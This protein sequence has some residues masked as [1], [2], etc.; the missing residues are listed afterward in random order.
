[1][2]VMKRASEIRV[3][4]IV[5]GVGFRPFIFRIAR[6]FR[7]HG[8]VWNDTWGVQIHAEGYSGDIERFFEE[9]RSNPPPLAV[10]QDVEIVDGEMRDFEDFAIEKSKV[11]ES[12]STFIPPDTMV[13]EDCLRELGAPDDRRYGYPFITCTNCGPRFSIVEDIPYDRDY[14]TMAT[15]GMCD[16]CRREY[17]DPA[18]RRF[19]TQP[20]ACPVCG[21]RLSLRDHRGTI[22]SEDTDE[23]VRFTVSRLREGSIFA[24]KGVGGY[25]LAADATRDDALHTL[26]ERKRRPFKPFALM[27]GSLGMIESFLEVSEKE[28]ELLLSR[29]RPIVILREKKRCVSALVAPSMEYHGI[30]LP[31]MPFQFQ[32]F[33]AAPDMVLVMTSGNVSEEPIVFRDDEAI[34]KLGPFVDYVISYNRAIASH[35]DDSVLFVEGGAPYFIRRSRGYVP[36]PFMRE[37]GALQTLALGGDMKNCFALSRGGTVIMSQHLGDISTPSGNRLFRRTVDMFRKIYDFN[38][39]AVAADL[40]PGYFTTSIADEFQASGLRRVDVQHHHAHIASVMDEKGLRDSVIGLAFDGTGFGTDGTLW[41]SEFLVADRRSFERAAH[42]SYFQLPGGESAIHDVWKIAVSM[43]YRRFG[44]SIPLFADEPGAPVLI[45]MMRK[46]I[47]SPETCSIGRIFDGIAAMLGI[48]RT[49]STEAEAAQ[50][51]EMAAARGI[52]QSAP[53][54]VVPIERRN[55]MVLSTETLVEYV[56]DLMKKGLPVERIAWLFHLSIAASTEKVVE[57]IA[58][59]HA[60]R[61]V[62]LSGGS[63]QNRLLLRLLMERLVA[64]GFTVYVPEQ[65]PVNDGCLAAGQIAVAREHLTT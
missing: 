33:D 40:H 10:I 57:I 23:I 15:F 12:R 60:I 11:L 38:P 52:D 51:L 30:M 43:L 29:E 62:V 22:I 63:F 37:H 8:R 59:E 31:Y 6:D 45:E 27:A 46:G 25:L 36:V 48:A 41:G 4:G 5:Q 2:V 7:I 47:N 49:I 21:P 56:I 39:E 65:V 14:T 19:H 18:N 17:E 44:D 64:K 9:I 20:V 1:M 53:A 13:C 42:F 26:R 54:F 28:K 32:L 16:E 3:R 50:L 24:I 58:A 35:T 34:L 55:H 61:T